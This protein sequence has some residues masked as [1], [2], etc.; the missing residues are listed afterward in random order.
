MLVQVVCE[1]GCPAPSLSTLF[2]E[3]GC[4]TEPGAL[5]LAGTPK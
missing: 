3:T 4:L 5:L 1:V 2:F